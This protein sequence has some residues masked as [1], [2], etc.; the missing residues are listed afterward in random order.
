M[1]RI[2]YNNLFE[3]CFFTGLKICFST[4][5]FASENIEDKIYVERIIERAISINIDE[6]WYWLKL[7]H[8]KKGILGKYESEIDDPH[9]FN[10][11]Y[12]KN[13]PKLELVETLKAF[14]LENTPTNHNLHAQCRFPAKFEYLDKKLFFDR[15]KI[16]I[17]SCSNFKKWYNDLPKHKVVL[18]FPTFYDGMPATMF[19]HTL[20]YFKDKKKSNLMNFAV[21]YAALVDLE[22]ENSIK[23]VFMGIFG[24]YIGEFSLNRYYLKIA[25]YNEIENRDIWEYE[26]NLKPEEIKKLYLH[27][28]ELQSTY[29]NYF[30]FKENCSYHLL[31][32]LEI[33]R[34]GL[35]L[36]ND[37]YFWTTPAET[38]KQIYDFK[39]VDKKVYRPSRR[40]IFKNRYD[41]LNK[42]NKF[43]VDYYLEYNSF[44]IDSYE[45]LPLKDKIIVLDTLSDYYRVTK[46]K[47]KYLNVVKERRKIKL[48]SEQLDQKLYSSSPELGHSTSRVGLSYIK[49][50]NEQEFS[51]INFRLSYH[52]LLSNDNGYLPNSQIE[53]ISGE[54]RN[55]ENQQFSLYSL[56][57]ISVFSLNPVEYHFND[58]SW[59]ANLSIEPNYLEKLKDSKKLK[60]NYGFGYTF[61]LNKISLFP[62]LEFNRSWLNKGYN[63]SETGFTF[64]LGTILNYNQN[65]KILIKVENELYYDERDTFQNYK[66][67]SNYSF[68]TDYEFRISYLDHSIYKEIKFTLNS[69]Y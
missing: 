42:K 47:K 25:E 30:Y 27:L 17:I 35:N 14:F 33:A 7:N 22:N 2:K 53:I 23:Y 63:K 38:I 64:S 1:F 6:D 58:Y 49:D 45:N 39:L 44:I 4:V 20:L 59:K 37:Y 11:K 34:P 26:L 15:A 8:Y 40:S 56:N 65:F 21:N 41:K 31:S 62:M 19:G 60:I 9:F 68:L 10:S 66:F 51:G 43:I 52:D 12:G 55:N 24:G 67:E 32:L 69:H 50:V 46:E 13:D 29:F 36:Q 16:T 61:K 18:S 48:V 3:T 57:I 5:L 54:I 28:W